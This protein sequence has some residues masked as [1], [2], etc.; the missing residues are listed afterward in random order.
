MDEQTIRKTADVARLSLKEEEVKQLTLDI[1]KL[2]D[3][4][5]SVQEIKSQEVSGEKGGQY[6]YGIKNIMRED[7]DGSCDE[8]EADAIRNEFTQKDGKYLTAPKSIK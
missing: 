4:F 6:H 2:L 8:S 3:H 1:E 7:K 5:K